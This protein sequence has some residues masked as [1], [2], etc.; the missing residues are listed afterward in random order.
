MLRSLV[1]G[2]AALL[3]AGSARAEVT[4]T[5]TNPERYTDANISTD[6]PVRADAPALQALRR[7]FERLGR[8]LPPGRDLRIEVLD[9]DLAGRFDARRALSPNTRVLEP[10]TWPRLRLR[11]ALMQ[12]GRV[13]AQGEEDVADRLYLSRPGL[14]RSGDVMQYETP[15]LEDW[16]ARLMAAPAG[17]T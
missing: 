5:F 8:R 13:L 1:F 3:I 15:M 6:R 9:V 10:T 12:Q 11:Y 4:V 14:V 2:G 16:F 17:G 7:E